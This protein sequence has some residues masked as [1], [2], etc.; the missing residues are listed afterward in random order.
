VLEHELGTWP[1]HEF[2]R[3]VDAGGIRWHIQQTG[4]GPNLLLIHGTAASTHSWRDLIPILSRQF[5][6]LALD[7]PGHGF[8]ASTTV[9]QSSI[10][11]MSNL[12]VALLNQL[13]FVPQFVV[14]HSAGAVVLANMALGQQ[15]DPRVIISVNGAFL[16]LVGTASALFAP[17]AKLLATSSYLPRLLARRAA[18][19]DNV[20]RVLRST[21]SELSPEGV[22][23]YVRL[24]RQPSHIRGALRMMSQWDLDS[25]ISQLALLK[26]PLALLV[27]SNDKAV[28][29]Q[30]AIEVMQHVKN[31]TLYPLAGLGHLAHE[32][33]PA[34]VADRI[35]QICTPYT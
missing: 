25:F 18:H 35:L 7:L 11:G 4:S 32:E 13:N 23:L 30:Q 3:F 10:A 24:V 20:A 34:L 26:Q 19:P 1:N 27:A 15:I 5:T 22:E 31:A 17:L 9:P 14:G 2:S 16:P 33:A 6:V 29:L 21:G 8:T 28:S 12:V